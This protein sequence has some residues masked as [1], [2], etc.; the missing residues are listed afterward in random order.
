[1]ITRL[2]LIKTSLIDYPGKVAAVLF[3]AGCNFYCPYCHNP[4][5]VSGPVP[6]DFLSMEDILRFLEKRRPVL[7]GVVITGGEPLLHPD[8]G[9]LTGAIRDLGLEIKIDTNGSFPAKLEQLRPDFVAMD[10]KTSFSNYSRVLPS[11]TAA[12][13]IVRKIRESLKILIGNGIPHQ[14][15]TTIVPGIVAEEDFDMIIP[16]VRGADSYLLSGY[17]NQRT[18]DS[19]WAEVDPYPAEVL[20]GIAE[21]LRLAGVPAQIRTN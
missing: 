6:E 5:L 10:I 18:L 3:T 17:R 15:R 4:E 21:K 13:Q 7:G 14:L 9:V 12:E 2:G 19:S 1:M 11:G 8:I 20:E 16:E